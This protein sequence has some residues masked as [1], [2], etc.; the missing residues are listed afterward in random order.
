MR[1][2]TD[3]SPLPASR[4]AVCS[5]SVVPAVAETTTT[6]S[7][8]VLADDARHALERGR[9]G[10]GG[11][12][13]L[14]DGAGQRMVRAIAITS[15]SMAEAVA[16]PPA[17]G[18]LN[19]SAAREVGLDGD[20]VRRSV[21]GALERARGDFFGTDA[22]LRRAL[23]EVRGREIADL[24]ATRLGGLDG[25]RG[26]PAQRRAPHVV[27]MEVPAL[28]EADEDRQLVRGVEAVDV[29]GRVRLG[30]ALRDRFLER[31]VEPEARLHARADVRRRSVQ[32]AA[33]D[34]RPRRGQ[35][36]RAGDERDR[37][38]DRRLEAQ[39]SLR[40]LG[41]LVERVPLLRDE[42]LVRRDDVAAA[43]ERGEVQVARR[44]RA[45][46]DLDDDVDVRILEQPERIG[47]DR[48]VAG[49]A[50][51]APVAHRGAD[52]PERPAGRG[53]EAFAAVRERARDRRTRPCRARAARRRAACSCRP[54]PGDVADDAARTCLVD[55][56]RGAAPRACRA[57]KSSSASPSVTRDSGARAVRADRRRS[58]ID[59]SNG[60][61]VVVR[62]C[63]RRTKRPAIDERPRPC[64]RYST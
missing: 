60:T 12:A 34:A 39:L 36:P 32:Q 9:R 22:S 56:V 23:A 63:P 50:R 4:A 2:A 51:L 38:G 41:R 61:G 33:H 43:L 55:A 42:L 16:S 31:G 20:D 62:S 54:S 35:H 45:A 21:G 27:G 13:E 15:P 48:E 17:P 64:R 26:Q 14:E 25:V 30:V 49:V 29:R 59:C 58:S 3:A 10:H 19:T 5:A 28:E 11:P 46:D 52:E 40:E 44:R 6:R 24:R 8:F 1:S 53:V 57:S 18:P 7:P 37:R 47:R